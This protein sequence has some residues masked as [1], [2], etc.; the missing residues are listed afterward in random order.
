[1]EKSQFLT[2]HQ[3]EALTLQK[4]IEI[5]QK[6]I[7][8]YKS[9]DTKICPE[10]VLGKDGCY[11]YYDEYDLA[12]ELISAILEAFENSTASDLGMLEMVKE[13]IIHKRLR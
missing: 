6:V 2:S 12:E 5:N 3:I 11:Y 9:G 4:L 10:R 7:K 1:M 8:N 13:K